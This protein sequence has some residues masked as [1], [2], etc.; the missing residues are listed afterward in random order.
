MHFSQVFAFYFN[1][2]FSLNGSYF[3]R[4][5]I[6]ARRPTLERIT[7]YPFKPLANRFHNCQP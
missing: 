6:L 7:M 4:L 3:A 1:D 5:S 2:R